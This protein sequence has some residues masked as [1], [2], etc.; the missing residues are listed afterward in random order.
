M[1]TTQRIDAG[2]SKLRAWPDW[3]FRIPISISAVV[4]WLQAITAGQFMSGTYGSLATHRDG[5][6]WSMLLLTLAMV[7]AVAAWFLASGHPLWPL[8]V[9]AAVYVLT[10]LQWWI[11]SER[12]LTLHVPLGV[13]IVTL[14]THLAI[15]SWRR[16][17]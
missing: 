6:N 15:W 9:T 4:F 5:A 3:L 16:G 13:L 11:G 1:S 10:G 14:S 7:G 2:S 8:A 12:V 17:A